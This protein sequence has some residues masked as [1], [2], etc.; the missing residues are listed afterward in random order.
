MKVDT[1]AAFLAMAFLFIEPAAANLYKCDGVYQDHPCSA[2]LGEG[3]MNELAQNNIMDGRTY[4]QKP[5]HAMSSSGPKWEAT[6]SA[7][8]DSDP[9]QPRPK[10][11]IQVGMDRT[12]VERARGKPDSRDTTFLDGRC[13]PGRSDQWVYEG[14]ENE[15]TQFVIFCDNRVIEIRHTNF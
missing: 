3:R 6:S 5:R 11:P 9:V 15:L 8:E 1:I 14:S 2:D 4:E 13:G 7:S 10:S 12:K